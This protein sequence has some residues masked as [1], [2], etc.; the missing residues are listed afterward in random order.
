MLSGPE[1]SP[2]SSSWHLK[3]TTNISE[4]STKQRFLAEE[5]LV[6]VAFSSHMRIGVGGGG[7]DLMNHSIQS[8]DQLTHTNS[9]L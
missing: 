7:E 9:T 5:K 8:R 4:E 1:G 2:K 3:Q 6:V